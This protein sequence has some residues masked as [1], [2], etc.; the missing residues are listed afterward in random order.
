MAR[1]QI[2]QKDLNIQE[3]RCEY[4]VSLGTQIREAYISA[5]AGRT[6]WESDG[7]IKGL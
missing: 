4:S 6:N 7:Y 3:H 2:V 5:G 1:G